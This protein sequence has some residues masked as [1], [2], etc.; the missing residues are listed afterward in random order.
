MPSLRTQPTLPRQKYAKH[1]GDGHHRNKYE[2]SSNPRLQ[3]CKL[4]KHTAD[5]LQTDRC[6]TNLP[7]VTA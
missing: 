7:I 6:S 3:H 1:P 4:I 2:K 5:I